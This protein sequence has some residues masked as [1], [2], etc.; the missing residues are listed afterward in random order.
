MSEKKTTQSQKKST[1]EAQKKPKENL[2]KKRLKEAEGQI[3][4]LNDRLL[5]TVAELDNYRK[6]T[7]REVAHIIQNANEGLIKELLPIIDDFERSLRMENGSDDKGFREGVE[8]IYHKLMSALQSRGLEPMI[9]VDQPF[10]VDRHDALLQVEK[11]GKPS[12]VVLEEHEKGYLLNNR[13]LRHA[14]VLVSK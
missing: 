13:V 4:D 11:K 3:H 12:G 1:K 2:L 7:E 5:R 10:D 14:K 8:F 9:S 6:R